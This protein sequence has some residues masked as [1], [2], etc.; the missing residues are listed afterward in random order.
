MEFDALIPLEGFYHYGIVVT[1]FDKAL[2]EFGSTLGLEWASVQRRQF[3]L[4]Q[5]NGVVDVDF[6]VTYSVT[7]PP[8]YE[9]IEATPGSIWDPHVA[10]GVHHLGF[11]SHDLVADSA[12]LT[13]AGYQWEATYDTGEEGVPFGFTYHTLPSAGLRIEL[14]DISRKP[15][16][17]AWFA[18]GDFPSALEERDAS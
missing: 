8:H 1:D 11:W 7:G 12:A 4:R 14:V 6:R 5:P 18:G 16:M 13:E 15:A 2:D 3:P 17:D 9:I 10:H